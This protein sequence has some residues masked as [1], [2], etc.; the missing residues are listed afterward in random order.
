MAELLVSYQ[1]MVIMVAQAKFCKRAGQESGRN[2]DPGNDTHR[3]TGMLARIVAT[4]QLPAGRTAKSRAKGARSVFFAP[5]FAL[6]TA[7]CGQK[8]AQTP[9]FAPLLSCLQNPLSLAG[10]QVK[11]Q[12]YDVP[13]ARLGGR[14]EFFLSAFC[15]AVGPK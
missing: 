5:R 6:T 14:R 8:V 12:G 4:R 3:E 10:Q 11:I 7:T 13:M 2:Q 9:D 15:H 1:P